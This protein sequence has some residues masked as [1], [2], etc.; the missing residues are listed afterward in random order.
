[1][2]TR[3]VAVLITA[4]T[5]TASIAGGVRAASAEAAAGGAPPAGC[6]PAGY[7]A[8]YGIWCPGRIQLV[9]PGDNLWELAQIFLG[10]G[11][12][13]PEIDILG[14]GRPQPCRRAQIFPGQILLIPT[15]GLPSGPGQAAQPGSCS[16]AQESGTPFPSAR[17]SPGPATTRQP[18][19]TPSAHRHT[20]RAPVRLPLEVLS[21]LA[22]AVVIG[23][24]AAFACHGRRRRRPGTGPVP[25]LDPGGPQPALP[26]RGPVSRRPGGYPFD[27]DGSPEDP[28]GPDLHEGSETGTTGLGSAA[29]YVPRDAPPAWPGRAVTPARPAAHT[30]A[31]P[32]GHIPL[33]TRDGQVITADISALGGLGLT[34]PGASAAARAVLAALLSE[35]RSGQEDPAV[36]VIVPADAAGLLLAP[37]SAASSVPGIIPGLAQPASLTTA[38]DDI[39]A[40]ILRRARLAP[41]ADDEHGPLRAATAAGPAVALFAIPGRA[42]TRR[43]HSI[44]AS[45]QDFGVVAVMLGEWPSGVTCYVAADGMITAASPRNTG[46]AGVQL[47]CLSLGD[48]SAATGLKGAPPSTSP[49]EDLAV[50][51]SRSPGRQASRPVSPASS[52][53]PHRPPVMAEPA[54]EGSRLVR[55]SVLGPLQITA[56]GRE[57]GA[58]PR[59]AREL[60]A[61][62]AVH[63]ADGVTADAISEAL[64]PGAPPGYGTRQ[65]NI[66][67]RK[68]RD[69][70]R[71][72]A[73]R[74]TPMWIILTADR[75]RLDPAL[76]ESDLWQFHAALEA[77]RTAGTD[78]DRLA[79]Y[80]Q[81]ASCYRGPLCDGAG[82]D[83]A[84][85]HAETA[86]H[87]ALDAW[88]RT[89]GILQDT[90]PEQAL[91]ALE[92]ALSH[93]PYNEYIYQQIMRLHAAQGRTDAV[94]RTFELL[95]ARLSE[96]GITTPRTS[97]RQAVAD[98]LGDSGPYPRPD[99]QSPS[100]TASTGPP[101]PPGTRQPGRAEH[102]R[103]RTPSS[104]PG[105]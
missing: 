51:A 62:L 97:T 30:G 89:A 64:W 15:A 2:L 78:Q 58:G 91:A 65:R 93:D 59:K 44:I 95:Q 46:L 75:Y 67:L 104:E 26:V 3:A 18:A 96:L 7:P 25:Q 98:L 100:T 5:V 33:G 105:R 87:R 31:P 16:P 57:I 11:H 4:A 49:D 6:G 13:W 28:Y 42:D 68:A 69:L 55:I 56:A 48:F 17:P 81:A 8:A 50:P 99:R 54:P 38:L 37:A 45:G 53:D 41:P 14:Q 60:L 43:L 61:F 1:M 83:W 36:P 66:A 29:S 80:R 72:A 74:S 63:G 88:T 92:T 84:E 24:A 22:V 27:R 73:G 101:A 35:A 77:A 86:R 90:D 10:N 21:G 103:P 39:E 52:P 102:R 47:H 9:V 20:S 79:A 40:L 71:S 82:Y 94:R 76:I 70:L 34:G 32:A 19:A 85:P 12:L 23:A